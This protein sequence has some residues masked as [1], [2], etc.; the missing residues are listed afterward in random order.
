MKETTNCRLLDHNGVISVSELAQYVGRRLPELT[1][2][3]QR[4]GL[5]QR[6]QVNMF[7]AGL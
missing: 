1:A 2:G 4:L 3:Q 6:F 7:V 5:D